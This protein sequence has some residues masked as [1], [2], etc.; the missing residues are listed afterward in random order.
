[1]EVT[2]KKLNRSILS[3]LADP[4]M[5]KIIECTTLRSMS[6]PEII[7]EIDIPH[8]TAYRK[9]KWLVDEDLLIV[10]NIIITDDGKKYSMFRSVYRSFN[11]TYYLGKVEIT[12]VPNINKQEKM[13]NHFFS[14]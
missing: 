12:A 1:M 6:V 5:S 8:T 3:A 11:V 10:E 13:A 14:V 9:I 4:E 2:S 7:K